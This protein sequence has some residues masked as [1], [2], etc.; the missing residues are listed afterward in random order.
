MV[1]VSPRGSRGAS[2][3]SSGLDD[4]AAAHFQ[5]QRVAGVQ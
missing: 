2:G 3:E 5:V 1:S 4:H